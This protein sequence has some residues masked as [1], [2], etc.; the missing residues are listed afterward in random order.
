MSEITL[1]YLRADQ[2]E[3]DPDNPRALY[4]PE[5][6]QAMAQSISEAGGVDQALIVTEASDTVGGYRLVDG[7]MRWAG[8]KMLGA[9]APDL[10]CEV[11][12]PMSRRERLLIMARTAELHFAKDPISEA[13]HYEKLLNEEGMTQLA[14]AR[15]LGR[16]PALI[17]GRLRLLELDPEV[18]ELVARRQLSKDPRIVGALNSIE[19]RA[20]RIKLAFELARRR[21]SILSCIAAAARLRDQLAQTERHEKRRQARRRGEQPSIEIA[22]ERLD[23]N[24]P[25][26]E[27]P[28]SWPAVREAAAAE[29]RACDVR[30]SVLAEVEEPAWTILAHGAEQT[31]QDCGL[32]RV[33][34]ACESCPLPEYLVRLVRSTEREQEQKAA[35][36]NG[37]APAR[38]AARA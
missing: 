2:I 6:V 17:A 24:L 12:P 3:P 7:H 10:K 14:L 31:C 16:S 28:R 20:A 37:R 8:A 18:R 9:D 30:A 34:A 36:G 5:D 11:R 19:D 27:V 29:C 26:D 23:G 15:A 35:R 13:R 1:R 33:R 21:A 38:R 4:P 22:S 25:P 32:A